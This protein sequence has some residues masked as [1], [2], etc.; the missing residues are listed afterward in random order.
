MKKKEFA[1]LGI[2]SLLLVLIGVFFIYFKKIPLIAKSTNSA[3]NKNIIVK[4]TQNPIKIS[5]LSK[6]KIIETNSVFEVEIILD[7]SKNQINGADVVL[8]FDPQIL[9][10]ID[11]DNNKPNI[12][13]SAGNIFEKPMLLMNHADNS[14][15]I[16]SLSIGTLS[17][18]SGKGAYGAVQFKALKPVST[19][20]DFDQTKTKVAILDETTSYTGKQNLTPITIKIG[21]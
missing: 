19:K 16:I 3:Q 4:K 17:P 9:Q 10:V 5:L 14:K 7:T 15:G 21:N 2:G 1:I 18:F 20:I 13:I 6:D 12:Q 8:I 11:A